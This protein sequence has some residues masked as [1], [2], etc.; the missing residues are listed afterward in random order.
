MIKDAQLHF[1]DA[2]AISATG[3]STNVLDFMTARNVF[4]GKPVAV[5]IQAANVVGTGTYSFELQTDDN[6]AFSSPT[7]L[8]TQ[9]VTAADLDKGIAT[10]SFPV[11]S[12]V[13]RYVRLNFTLGGTGPSMTVTAF[14]QPLDMV[15]HTTTYVDASTIS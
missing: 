5:V 14:V 6:A 2:Q 8:S 3:V 11:S 1:S 15:P 13:E 10:L 7:V 9:A 12:K 4:E